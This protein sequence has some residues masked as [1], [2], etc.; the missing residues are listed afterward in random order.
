MKKRIIIIVLLFCSCFFAWSQTW[1]KTT[2]PCNK[3]LILKT[4][5]RWLKVRENDYDVAKV[6][7]Q[8]RLELMKRLNMI[9]QWIYDIYPSPTAV[10]AQPFYYTTDWHFA[11]QIQF[12]KLQNGK[13]RGN[14]VNGIPVV[15]YRY[16]AKFCGYH[17][18]RTTYEIMRGSGCEAPTIISVTINN[19][20]DLFIQLWLDDNAEI[21]RVDGR[22]IKM[23]SPIVGKW[24]GYD[25]YNSNGIY[26]TNEKIVF[27]F[28]RE[29]MLPYIPVTRKQ[30]LDR[31]FEC[32]KIF[33]DKMIRSSEQPEGLAVLM[34][35]KE[36]E[37]QTNKLK[38]QKDDIIKYYQG[39]LEATTKAGLLDAPA[40]LF[41]D[42]MP[43]L[44]QYPIFTTQTA[45]G[46][47]LVTENPAYIRRDL[48]KY[49][50]QLI[51]YKLENGA[52]YYI[53]QSLNPY[54]LI[55]DNFPIE[56]LQA[57]IDK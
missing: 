13:L 19:L 48:P 15:F 35:K 49:I 31:Y 28:H 4:P 5:G 37:V 26:N 52:V 55:D 2:T 7:S 45:G 43:I 29:G 12:E 56:K 42:I 18:G 23:L 33:Y 41:G 47:M 11:S 30:Y 24:K 9:H 14:D 3:E 40:I 20:D 16:A 27:L 17:C 53:D 6:S 25:V 8:Q 57:M 38:K 10:D 22:Q 54:K 21:M 50:P 44:T 32:L 39:E 36:R 46:K 34:D 51:V 1:V